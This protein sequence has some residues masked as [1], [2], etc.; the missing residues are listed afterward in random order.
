MTMSTNTATGVMELILGYYHN[1]DTITTAV[2]LAIDA[3]EEVEAHRDTFEWCNGCKEY[4][5]ER[6][7]CPRW[8]KAIRETV[9]ENKAALKIVNCVECIHRNTDKCPADKDFVDS[10]PWFYCGNG[11]KDEK[12]GT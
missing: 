3:L 1:N 8:N 6:H 7:C 2:R 11:E 4:D 9:E 10:N 5:N 12:T